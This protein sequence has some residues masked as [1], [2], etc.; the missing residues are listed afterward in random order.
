MFGYLCF[1]VLLWLLMRDRLAAGTAG[2]GSPTDRR[3]RW[4]LWLGIP[5]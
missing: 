1:A 3:S 4:E 5:G 2:E